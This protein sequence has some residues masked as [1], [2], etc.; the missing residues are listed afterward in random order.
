LTQTSSESDVL[1]YVE[2]FWPMIPRGDALGSLDW[3][4]GVMSLDI[5]HETWQSI[6]EAPA[7]LKTEALRV[8][9][10]EL[11]HFLQLSTMRF[12]HDWAKELANEVRTVLLRVRPGDMSTLGDVIARG[13]KVLTEAENATLEAHFMKLDTPGV[14]GLTPR[15]I[16][17]GQAFF[18]ERMVNY[19]I[20]ESHHFTAH[21]ERAPEAI[22]RIALD[23]LSHA[24]GYH[25]ALE[26]FSAIASASL[27]TADPV[28]AF[29]TLSVQLRAS[30][31]LGSIK[32]DPNGMADMWTFVQQAL[33][34][35]GF[36]LGLIDAEER[37]GHPIFTGVAHEL[38]TKEARGEF[39]HMA[40]F[41]QPE[42]TIRVLIGTWGIELPIVFR[43]QPPSKICIQS[44]SRLDEGSLLALIALS[45]AGRQITRAAATKS[46]R[47]GQ[48]KL[49]ELTWLV[50]EHN[51]PVLDLTTEE[52]RAGD[53]ARLVRL[54]ASDDDQ[55]R[56]R[57][58]YWGRLIV[59][60][61]VTLDPTQDAPLPHVPGCRELVR[62]F[63]ARM[64]AF[65]LFLRPDH[66]FFDWFGCLA[67]EAACVDGG[68][69]VAN[70]EVI[71]LMASTR[72]AMCAHAVA[73]NQNPWL[74]LECFFAGAERALR[75]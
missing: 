40:F 9:S 39:H 38:Q 3:I 19:D 14:G 11:F 41:A 5:S 1:S 2:L 29:E 7:E 44:P 22:Y 55:E 8:Y 4:G 57:H 25:V 73:R 37:P 53:A 62:A 56:T 17:E 35:A 47:F 26:W 28:S 65:P 63:H 54:F 69:D 74:L 50:A 33:S 61:P 12:M 23:F 48:A 72:E 59:R 42:T 43:P 27:C 36:E 34:E 21:L 10:H 58:T 45:A 31:Q 6:T 18:V 75:G 15:A 13:H 68:L 49:A 64:P 20:S 67:P 60:A 32:R 66:G 70:R 46:K 52:V 24:V 30:P 16:F 51:A 71:E